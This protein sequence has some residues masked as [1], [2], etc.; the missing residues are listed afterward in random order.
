MNKVI[1]EESAREA[2]E[3]EAADSEKAAADGE[4]AGVGEAEGRA[5]M[6]SIRFV[7]CTTGEEAQPAGMQQD[8]AEEEEGRESQAFCLPPPPFLP[9]SWGWLCC[10][11]FFFRCPL[12]SFMTSVSSF[13]IILDINICQ[14][15]FF[16]I[17]A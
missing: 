4:E 9:S 11:L 16:R 13:W 6:A 17:K 7:S 15:F 12:F 8:N 5:G 10:F 14:I 2:A 3:K 1:V